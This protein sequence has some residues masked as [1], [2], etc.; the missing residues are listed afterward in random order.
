M[1]RITK[2]GERGFRSEDSERAYND[3]AF[4]LREII[5]RTRSIEK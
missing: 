2:S 5:I 4:V 1:S 3:A